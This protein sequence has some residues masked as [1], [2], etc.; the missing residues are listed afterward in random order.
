VER[1]TL[2]DLIKE[3]NLTYQQLG[4]RLGVSR[5]MISQWN[6]QT[7]DPRISTVIKLAKELNVSFKVLASA[8]GKDTNGMPDDCSDEKS[9]DHMYA[10]KPL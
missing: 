8:M 1:K 3:A 5:S 6:N 10:K 4:D 9:N 2:K 7:A